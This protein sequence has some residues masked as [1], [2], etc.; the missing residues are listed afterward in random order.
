MS[1]ERRIPPFQAFFEEHRTL[2]RRFLLASVGPNDAE[3]T[4]QE[5]FLAA[6]RAYPNLRDAE[7]LRGWILQIAANKAIDTGRGKGRRPTVVA[8]IPEA[9]AAFDGR[10]PGGPSRGAGS[11]GSLEAGDGFDARD[12]LWSAVRTLPERMRT[13]VVLRHVLDRPYEDIAAAMGGTEDGARANVHQGLKRLRAS[14][15]DPTVLVGE[16]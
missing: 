7:N 9:A 12:P 5:T 10:G 15:A 2:V 6:L 3:D 4:F 14:L 1:D 8:E 11:S 13:A 16:E